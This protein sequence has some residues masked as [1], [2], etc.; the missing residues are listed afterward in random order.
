VSESTPP[1]VAPETALEHQNV[2]VEHRG[3]H[4]FLYGAG[5]D[6]TTGETLAPTLDSL[7]DQI[8]P[9]DAWCEVVGTA[10]MA[11]VYG[12]FD[13][14]RQLQYVNISRNVPL[15][16]KGHL[17]QLGADVC[18]FVRVQPFKFPQRQVMA[19]LQA[20]WVAENGTI[21]P[22]NCAGADL[23]TETPLAAMSPAER[24]AYEEKKL[25]LRK[26]MADTAL[27]LPVAVPTADQS[28]NLAAAVHS[29]DWSSVI[30]TQT[31]A[32]LTDESPI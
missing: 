22:G 29:D 27:V 5:D 13:R 11:G 28:Q 17:S 32:T 25:K 2:P 12:V 14:D 7:A 16:L 8:V 9:L 15:S 1:T 24:I 10:K 26:A 4:E 21:P 6:H 20:A 23:W 30:N 19:D 31:Q 18:S 3:L